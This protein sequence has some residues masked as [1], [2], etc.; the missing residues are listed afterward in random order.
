MFDLLRHPVIYPAGSAIVGEEQSPTGIYVVCQ[1]SVKI[2][3]TAAKGKTA[4][5]RTCGPGAIVGLADVL[6]NMPSQT[7][8]TTV[9]TSEISQVPAGQFRTL[10]QTDPSALAG[11]ARV[12]AEELRYER[13]RVAAIWL[14][15]S[16]RKRFRDFLRDLRT[17]GRRTPRGI[18]IP[19]PYTQSDL[20]ECLGCTRETIARLL[21]DLSRAGAAKRVGAK[22]ILPPES[23]DRGL[24]KSK[25]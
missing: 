2:T 12:L 19:F 11:V 21:R 9:T 6:S 22:L 16:A 13:G 15:P 25:Q 7:R 17:K 14:V 4:V 10:L 24:R 18:E 1:G 5:L 23:E 8:S 3:L 20:G